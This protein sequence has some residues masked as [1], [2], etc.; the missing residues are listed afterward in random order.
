MWDSEAVLEATGGTLYGTPQP[1]HSVSIDSR[2]V[3]KGAL[4]IALKGEFHDGHDHIA[5]AFA[6]GAS[7]ALVSHIPDTI[8]TIATYIVVKDTYQALVAL[9]RYARRRTRANIIAITGSVGKTGTKEALRT[10]LSSFGNVY[11][12]EGNLNNHIGLPLCLANLPLKTDFGI[13]EMGMNHA[14]EIRYLTQIAKP[15][16]AVITNVEAVHLEFFDSIEGIADAKAEIMEGLKTDGTIIL[17]RDNPHFT[18]LKEKADSLSIPTIL[19]FG[20]DVKADC[21]LLLY[22]LVSEKSEIEAV[23]AGKPVSYTLGTIGKHWAL[24]SL[25]ALTVVSALKKDIMHATA[26]FANF[27]EPAGRG[28]IHTLSIHQHPV[29]I[30]DDGYNASPV[31]V[32]GAIAKLAEYHTYKKS[33]R[34]IAV[35]G[36]MLELGESSIALHQSLLTA[37]QQ[38][39]IDKVFLAGERMQHLYAILPRHMQGGYAKHSAALA[40]ILIPQLED[41]D[42]IL[43]K[44]SHGSKMHLVL[45]A[46]N[47]GNFNAV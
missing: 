10:V 36:D 2:K 12:T 32:N 41:H 23:V 43:V 19:T 4:F 34:T 26:A 44:G 1:M 28:N 5:S 22:N 17:N 27:H 3:H 42:I 18:R 38:H 45:D 47:K 20:E 14:G 35:L 8:A 15:D 21:R 16:I 33:G 24:T 31:S 37:L 13:F 7:V 46:L 9:A 29:T 39:A 30:I 11:A 25:A 6:N 40:E